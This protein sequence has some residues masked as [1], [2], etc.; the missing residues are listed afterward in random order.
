MAVT[1]G[2][3]EDQCANAALFARRA[4]NVRINIHFFHNNSNRR[5][6]NITHN[7]GK[8]PPSTCL[9]TQE[10]RRIA[11]RNINNELFS[12]CVVFYTKSNIN[13]KEKCENGFFS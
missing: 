11:A 10:I 4:A 13:E 1:T 8:T 6:Y 2:A 9:L 7:S 5:V 12:V 3:Q